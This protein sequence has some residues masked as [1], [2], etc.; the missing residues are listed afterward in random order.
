MLKYKARAFALRDQ[1]SDVIHGL[2]LKE[3][4]EGE[5]KD[6]TP[7]SNFSEKENKSIKQALSVED[8]SADLFGGNNQV[9]NQQ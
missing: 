5:M 9:A 8:Q 1:F 3:E 7:V 6:I 2:H 4:M